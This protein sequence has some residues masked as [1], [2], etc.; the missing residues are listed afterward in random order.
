MNLGT[1]VERHTRVDVSSGV[2]NTRQTSNAR[3]NSYFFLRFFFF[4]NTHNARDDVKW[5]ADI[6]RKWPF[7]L[8]FASETTITRNSSRRRNFVRGVSSVLVPKKPLCVYE[9]KHAHEPKPFDYSRFIYHRTIY[10]STRVNV[11]RPSGDTENRS[12]R[13]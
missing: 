12:V 9:T 13:V 7:F 10:R 6:V 1:P 5:D 3:L 4:S 8:D 11:H 2:Y